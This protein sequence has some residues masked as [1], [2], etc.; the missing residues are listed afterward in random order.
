MAV[1]L[2]ENWKHYS[3]V[4]RGLS[5]PMTFSKVDLCFWFFSS[6]SFFIAEETKKSERT[7]HGHLTKMAEKRSYNTQLSYL[8]LDLNLLWKDFNVE[9][10]LPFFCSSSMLSLLLFI[11]VNGISFVEGSFPWKRHT[12]VTKCLSQPAK[13]SSKQLST[14]FQLPSRLY[15]RCCIINTVAFGVRSLDAF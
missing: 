7:F 13:V 9:L 2:F 14:Q 5:F 4:I 12:N 6:I 15:T 11:I 1:F 8:Y 3:F 10:V